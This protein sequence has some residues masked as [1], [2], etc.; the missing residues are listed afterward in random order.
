MLNTRYFT[1]RIDQV[2]TD[3]GQTTFAALVETCLRRKVPFYA[4]DIS[5]LHSWSLVA[6]IGWFEASKN[7]SG[8]R[9]TFPYG[10]RRKGAFRAGSD[11]AFLKV[12]APIKLPIA[13]R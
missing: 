13:M 10:S 4:N 7:W 11:F 1:L 12:R 8:L 6:P 3:L 2:R 9:P 5:S